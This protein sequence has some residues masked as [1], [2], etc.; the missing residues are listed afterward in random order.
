MKSE[1]VWFNRKTVE[2]SRQFI[3]IFD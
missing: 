3:D 1:V 2:L